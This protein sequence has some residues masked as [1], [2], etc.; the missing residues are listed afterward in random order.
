M[1]V[2]LISPKNEVYTGQA[3]LSQ[4]RGKSTVHVVFDAPIKIPLPEPGYFKESKAEEFYL[5]DYEGAI[6]VWGQ[7]FDFPNYALKLH[8]DDASQIVETGGG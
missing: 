1:K 3:I 6:M 4:G 8:P 2:R 7:G 5:S